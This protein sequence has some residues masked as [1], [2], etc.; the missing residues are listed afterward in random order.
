MI[1]AARV[2]SVTRLIPPCSNENKYDFNALLASYENYDETIANFYFNN[3]R[4]NSNGDI[5][6]PRKRFTERKKQEIRKHY[7]LT[8]NYAETAKALSSNELTVGIIVKSTVR[9]LKLSNKDNH[10]GAGRPLTYLKD[11]ES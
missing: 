2:V 8:G 10:S 6:I 9:Y 3:N 4:V 7:L 1:L 5:K 11:V